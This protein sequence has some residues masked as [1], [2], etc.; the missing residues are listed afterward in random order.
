MKRSKPIEG[1][2][3]P[4]FETGTEGVIW[5]VY[6]D[7]SNLF[8]R[9][10]TKLHTLKDGDHLTICAPD[11]KTVVFKDFIDLDWHAGAVHD[12][13]P[14]GQEALGMWVHGIQRGF[15]PD[16]WARLFFPR[17]WYGGPAI[18]VPDLWATLV[19]APKPAWRR[20]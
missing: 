19:K 14:G 2:L 9:D 10:Y 17:E 16:D 13:G 12:P 3:E 1:I 4:H 11:N 18:E 6:E 15:D 5:S 20:R 8:Y 7:R